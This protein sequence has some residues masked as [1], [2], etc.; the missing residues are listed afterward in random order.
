MYNFH[1][2]CGPGQ[3]AP[4]MADPS[5]NA[6]LYDNREEYTRAKLTILEPSGQLSYKVLGLFVDLTLEEGL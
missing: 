5:K 6:I 1:W 2:Q 4:R 3:T